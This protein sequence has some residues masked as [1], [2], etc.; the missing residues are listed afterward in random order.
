MKGMEKLKEMLCEEL[1]DITAKGSISAGDL[2]AIDKLTH[3]IKSI[4]T[5][6]AMGEYSNDYMDGKSYA[7]RRD[8]M[9]R[10]SRGHS[11]GR[12]DMMDTLH[13]LMDDAETERERDAI[14]RCIDQMK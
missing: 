12:D 1:E 5:I 11:Y 10:Y 4:E 6:M 2:D 3:S 13:G 14:R 9:G 8:S 7:R